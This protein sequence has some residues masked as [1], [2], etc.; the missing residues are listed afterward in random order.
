MHPTAETFTELDGV[1][2]DPSLVPMRQ[3][4]GS[5]ERLGGDMPE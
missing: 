2:V 4:D 5:D 3:N 1:K